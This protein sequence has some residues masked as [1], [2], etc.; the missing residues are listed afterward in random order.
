MA[1]IS[2]NEISLLQSVNLN[3]AS[4]GPLLFIRFIQETGLSYFENI[5][6]ISSDRLN[7]GEYNL[8]ERFHGNT[9]TSTADHL[10][11]GFTI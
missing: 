2:T 5:L 6:V 8:N 11:H 1:N 3:F 9:S 7:D 10:F 4:C